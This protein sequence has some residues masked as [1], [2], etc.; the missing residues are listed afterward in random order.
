[1]HSTRSLGQ[2]S[3][4]FLVVLAGGAAPLAGC[5]PDSSKQETGTLQMNL[6]GTNGTTNYRLTTAFFTISGPTPS[7][8][9]T[10]TDP[11]E[12]V[13]TATLRIGDYTITL[14]P[15]WDLQRFNAVTGNWETVADAILESQNPAAFTILANQT[16]TVPF[17][18]RV[19]AGVVTIGTGTLNVIINVNVCGNGTVEGTEE[20]DDGNNATGDGC[21]GTCQIE[22]GA[23]GAQCTV[24]AECITGVCTAGICVP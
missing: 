14:E 24:G 20:C 21:S 6:I 1:M 3:V 16:T 11:T 15:N 4:A 7:S 13:L 22:P 5:G 10:T 17:Q 12:T 18:F 8:L 2:V 19:N 9:T 23:V